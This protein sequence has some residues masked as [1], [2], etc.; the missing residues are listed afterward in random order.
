MMI[1]GILP[2]HWDIMEIV[3]SVIASVIGFILLSWLGLFKSIRS[4]IQNEIAERKY[5]KRL[6]DDC[7]NLVVVGKKTGFSLNKV[8]VSLDLFISDMMHPTIEM[9]KHPPKTFV[10]VGG[11]GA[12]KSTT[13]R[14]YIIEHIKDSDKF[15]I[16]F[17]LR[18][19]EYDAEE[20]I[21]KYLSR[22][23][24]RYGKNTS[25]A[26]IEDNLRDKS[27]LC[28]LDGLDEIKPHLRTKICDQINSFYSKFFLKAGRL[29]VTCRKEAYKAVALDI[30]AVW[31]VRPLSDDQIKRFAKKWPLEYPPEKTPDTFYRDLSSSPRIME[32]ARSPLLLVGGLMHYTES[33][34]GIPEER[35]EY[36]KSMAKWLIN[37]WGMAQGHVP[38]I[39]KTFYENILVNL[40]LHLHKQ[41]V[42]EISIENAN[43]YV[44]GIANKFGYTAE[45]SE[46]I[47]NSI[48]IKTG[49]LIKEG[50]SIFFAQFALQEYFA[51]I[52]LMDS[53][54]GLE[55]TNLTPIDWW[56]EVILLSVAQQ[57]DPTNVLSNLFELN[58]TLA[59]SA[60]AESPT[61]SVDMQELA[62]TTCL[63]ELDRQNE[64]VGSSL[65]SLLRKVRG[66]VETRLL[67]EL[68]RRL[69]NDEATVAIIGMS[70]ANAG[71]QEAAN[72]LMLH[73]EVWTL[74]LKKGGYLSTTFEN[75]LIERLENGDNS[76][77][78]K[79]C[80]LISKEL[81]E[82]RFNQ[83]LTL[84]PRLN[85][86]KRE[87]LSKTI[88]K[89]CFINPPIR[90]SFIPDVSCIFY[91]VSN[92]KDRKYFLKEIHP[93]SQKRVYS[94]MTTSIP[95]IFTLFYLNN[96]RRIGKDSR[97]ATIVK[98][99]C[100]NYNR[101]PIGL[102][103]ISVFSG[104]LIFQPINV[105][106][107]LFVL[108]CLWA[109]WICSSRQTRNFYAVFLNPPKIFLFHAF[110][111]LLGVCFVGLSSGYSFY[112]F[113]LEYSKELFCFTASMAFCFLGFIFWSGEEFEE[114]ASKK[115]LR[116]Y[117]MG[118]Y[119]P[120][121]A[122][123]F[124]LIGIM[125]CVIIIIASH[126]SMALITA[127]IISAV[128]VI[129]LILM[130]GNLYWCWR[131]ART[132]NNS[133]EKENELHGFFW[134]NAV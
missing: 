40:A 39:N 17:F 86:N 100:W 23:I 108:L 111:W 95:L 65:V 129:W 61:P 75:T 92:I 96:N 21:E 69:L 131:I 27:A 71:T 80:D 99:R 121:N 84:L 130:T 63:G 36:L 29:I 79:V 104:L 54:T 8:Y 93:V 77:A 117:L 120:L 90:G 107:P 52:Q 68:E 34:L 115:A 31:E 57:R 47:L 70:L 51:S 102:W 11:P 127:Q 112:F 59:I 101:V 12:G 14:K 82:D 123:A 72:T 132:A 6:A 125:T 53:E 33:N 78:R 105:I 45:D 46:E 26:F 55:L 113:P 30:P 87:Y 37:D 88:L 44:N 98:A 122:S 134:G 16:P 2:A 103:W 38:N 133:M 41:L 20:S 32:V 60:V 67:N 74:S 50:G 106:R 3:Y 114:L 81:T 13:V 18:L 89:E 76:Q 118:F 35:F 10:L 42:S 1:N 25:L 48:A 94:D 119:F 19:R 28:I 66:R 7:N 110:I 128:Y 97:Q 91:L 58:S 5:L 62:I 109:M 83:L 64:S 9:Q 43:V 85:E 73:P 49:V 24:R 126:H 4:L 15:N 116:K 22:R 124:Y 56:R